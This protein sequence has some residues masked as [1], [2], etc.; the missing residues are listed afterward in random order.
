MLGL[1]NCKGNDWGGTWRLKHATYPQA[2]P[3]HPFLE[4]LLLF[5]PPSSSTTDA[6][7]I[8]MTK[9]VLAQIYQ[10][11][12]DPIP[13]TPPMPPIHQ[14][15]NTPKRMKRN[16]APKGTHKTFLRQKVL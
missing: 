9:L 14:Y 11:E 8:K 12:L 4:Q 1:K 3:I 7:S 16:S 6:L 5:I 2:H 13:A 15:T 10:S